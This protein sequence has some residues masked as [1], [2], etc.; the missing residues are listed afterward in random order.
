MGSDLKPFYDE[1]LDCLELLAED[2][3]IGIDR[4][5]LSRAPD[6]A[7]AARSSHEEI[8]ER[9]RYITEKHPEVVAVKDYGFTVLHLVF[10]Y[11]TYRGPLDFYLQV[12]ELF[13]K[14]CPSA[15]TAYSNEGKTPLMEVPFGPGP[16]S[17][18]ICRLFALIADKFP[19]F[20]ILRHG[21]KAM[22]S[23]HLL[24]KFHEDD[25]H[26]D[27]V[28]AEI[29][30]VRRMVTAR[31]EL[32]KLTDMDGE[33]AL[34]YAT[35]YAGTKYSNWTG[36]QRYLISASPET[37]A[38]MPTRTT[39]EKTPLMLVS[40]Q[41]NL[42][43]IDNMVQACPHAVKVSDSSGLSALHDFVWRFGSGRPFCECDTVRSLCQDWQVA[44][45]VMKGNQTPY[46]WVANGVA[47]HAKTN[48]LQH[49][50]RGEHHAGNT[51]TMT[52][53]YGVTRSSAVAL[54]ELLFSPTVPARTTR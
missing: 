16:P 36:V 32:L 42:E 5:D 6:G 41:T 27:C 11:C 45:L 40:G 1:I 43:L 53:L 2:E 49:D 33:T 10:S 34:H 35:A 21:R 17:P 30:V 46:K 31:P 26:S 22:T 8:L 14:A 24:L 13:M 15:F 28:E 4:G 7:L 39:W 23:L 48:L 47:K 54:L 52:Y 20:L 44:V 29:D 18:E 25:F 37:V 51:E 19:D 38:W 12:V 3:D 9:F 50:E